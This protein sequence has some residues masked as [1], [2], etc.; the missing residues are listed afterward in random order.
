MDRK[1]KLKRKKTILTVYRLFLVAM[2][3]YGA[4][5]V[6]RYLKQSNAGKAVYSSSVEAVRPSITDPEI[7]MEALQKVNPDIV[8][9]L[10]VDGTSIDFPVLHDKAFREVLINALKTG[11]DWSVAREGTNKTASEIFYKYLYNDYTG[12]PSPMGSVT[13]D[14]RVDSAMS[15]RYVLIYGH[16]A[17]LEGIMFSDL[18]RYKN[19][20]YCMQNRSAVL[21]TETSR[22]DLELISV[23]NV[24]GYDQKIFGLNGLATGEGFAVQ[25]A[26]NVLFSNAIYLAGRDKLPEE[27]AAEDPQDSGPEPQ[28]AGTPD[29]KDDPNYLPDDFFGGSTVMDVPGATGRYVIL[30]TCYDAPHPEDPA[31][32]VLLFKV[33]E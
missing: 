23:S 4:W 12:K 2:I 25:D 15:G 11:G 16:N 10:I 9:W 22:E 5:G 24:S 8:G 30:S 32:L 19:V 13:I 17:G 1:Q 14:V 3:I 21:F 18:E 6:V 26:V 33:K 29:P 28:N 31:R 27:P 7:R 20:E